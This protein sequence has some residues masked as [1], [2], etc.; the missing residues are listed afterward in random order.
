MWQWTRG[1]RRQST[2]LCSN[3]IIL[4]SYTWCFV[5]LIT[6]QIKPTLLLYITHFQCKVVH[7]GPMYSLSVQLH[8][9]RT[10]QTGWTTM[11]V[12]RCTEGPGCLAVLAWISCVF[13]LG[14]VTLELRWVERKSYVHGMTLLEYCQVISSDYYSCRE[15]VK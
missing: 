3:T 13:A 7:I 10:D 12:Y 4:C 9:D 5:S 1:I 2:R 14:W 15:L 6:R 11:S 8:T